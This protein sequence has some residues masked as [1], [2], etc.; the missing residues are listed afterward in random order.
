MTDPHFCLFPGVDP[1]LG[2]V[3][4]ARVLYFSV[5]PRLY[6]YWLWIA[7]DIIADCIFRF[8]PLLLHPTV[9]PDLV[10][11]P[12]P[13][14]FKRGLGIA[15]FLG[16]LGSGTLVPIRV[17]LVDT[18]G[19][20][21]HLLLV[22]RLCLILLIADNV[23][24][25]SAH[26]GANQDTPIPSVT[27]LLV[28]YHGPQNPAGHSAIAGL[29]LGIAAAVNDRQ[30]RQNCDQQLRQDD[31]LSFV[32]GVSRL[33]RN[34]LELHS[35]STLAGLA[36]VPLPLPFT[37]S[38]G[39][40]EGYTRIREQARI[41]LEARTAQSRRF[42]LLEMEPSRGFF[43]LPTP[44]AG[45][46]FF[47]LEGDVFVGPGGLEYLFGIATADE[48][49]TLKYESRCARAYWFQFKHPLPNLMFQSPLNRGARAYRD[50]PCILDL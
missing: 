48:H 45:D 41:Q 23:S 34:E 32:A 7:M 28:A 1:F 44:S 27:V 46:V 43:R 25:D 29:C 50:C 4:V 22:P 13:T 20:T 30:Q 24:Q 15:G 36:T 16:F 19:G 39:S 37:P 38:R 31:H 17:I 11:P 42:E 47:D 14:F 18:G 8:Y 49:G 2:N 21:G 5:I 35:V 26:G 6:Q 33:Q 40:R 9:H 3:P 10:L 12:N